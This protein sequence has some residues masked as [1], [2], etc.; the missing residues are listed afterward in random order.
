MSTK[1]CYVTILLHCSYMRLFIYVPLRLF[2]HVNLPEFTMNS[3]FPFLRIS[4][5]SHK[6]SNPF[7]WINRVGE[8]GVQVPRAEIQG[9]RL[10]F[11]ISESRKQIDIP[12]VYIDIQSENIIYRAKRK[13][14]RWKMQKY[15]VKTNYRSGSPRISDIHGVYIKYTLGVYHDQWGWKKSQKPNEFF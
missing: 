3:Y 4:R 13:K 5:E 9:W 1:E 15:R 6:G 10:N 14:Y 11:Q 8:I 2:M 7:C 12:V